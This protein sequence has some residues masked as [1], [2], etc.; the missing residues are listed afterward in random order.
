MRSRG[1]LTDAAAFL[2]TVA[3]VS[4]GAAASP[5]A[6]EAHRDGC[7]RWHSCP[8]DSGSYVCGDLGYYDQCP[9]GDP[10]AP[11]T[12]P[13][14]EEA[15]PA[16]DPPVEET[17]PT[18]V[19][20]ADGDGD[21]VV[22]TSDACPTTA[23]ATANGCP[24]PA[25]PADTDGDGKPDAQDLCPTKR[26]ERGDG[27]PRGE[28]ITARVVSVVDGDT[29]K[30]RVRKKKVTVRLIGI[31]TPESV[32]PGTPVECGAKAAAAYLKK[33][34]FKGKKG[35]KVTLTTDPTQDRNDRYGRLLAYAKVNSGQVLQ[36]ELLRAGWA[37]VYV[38]EKK[39]ERFTEFA[40]IASG[41]YFAKRGVWGSCAGN[42][43]SS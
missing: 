39:F 9:G 37:T 38:Y 36:A 10:D 19:P 3:A 1:G 27:C 41:A 13:P 28:R 33:L 2:M 20:P 34:S 42:F 8:S 5:P 24:P 18:V 35:R 31:D 7:H 29:I 12:D 22:D 14:A 43:H 4:L 30:V 40:G 17:P 6:T 16:T 21:G 11:P 26:D 23:A 15:P 32:K 25:P